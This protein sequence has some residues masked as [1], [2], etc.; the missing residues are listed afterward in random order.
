MK[1]G[2]IID[3][4]IPLLLQVQIMEMITYL[5]GLYVLS[6]VAGDDLP[7]DFHLELIE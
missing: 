5:I 3:Y 7:K 2:I 6:K 1:L 4:H